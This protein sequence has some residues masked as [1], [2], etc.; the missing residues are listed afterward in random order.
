MRVRPS[1]TKTR[2]A[3]FSDFADFGTAFGLDLS[4]EPEAAPALGAPAASGRGH[5]WW[6]RL[7]ARRT[8]AR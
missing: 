3:D 4:L 5:A 6:R 2:P 1:A 7:G 8:A